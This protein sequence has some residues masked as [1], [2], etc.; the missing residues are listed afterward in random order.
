MKSLIS[1]G[2]L[3]IGIILLV[4]LSSFQSGAEQPASTTIQAITTQF[5]HQLEAFQ[6]ATANYHATGKAFAEGTATQEALQEAHLNTRLAFKRASYLLEYNDRYSIKK[7]INGAPL[8]SVEPK[9]PEVA[10]IEPTGLQVLD[11]IVFADEVAQEDLLLHLS[12]LEKA[13]KRVSN[14]Q[15]GLMLGHRKVL[16]AIQLE[17]IRIFTLG[18]T[19]FDTPGSL[20]A[21]PEAIVSLESMEFALQQYIPYL[22]GK[23]PSLVA[24]VKAAFDGALAQLR[25]EDDFDTFNRLQFYRNHLQ[26]LQHTVWEVQRQLGIETLSEVSSTPPPLLLE[27]KALF[28]EGFFND[29]YFRGFELGENGGEKIALG[30]LLF[31]DPVLSANNERACA[32]CHN[33][34]KAFTDG[35]TTSLAIDE[36]HHIQRNSPTLLNSM[37]AERFFYDL[38]EDKLERQIKHVVMDANEFSTDFL[39]IIEKL[40]QSEEYVE[41]FT[42]AYPAAKISKY[43]I[44]NA[45]AAY[46]GTLQS[47][48]SP[49]D[50]YIT[51][52]SDELDAA[53][54]RGFNLFMGKAACGTCHFA[55]TFSG[56]VPPFYQ[57]NESEVL[58][59]PVAPDS[60][61]VD[62]DM[63]RFGSFRPIDEAPFYQFSFKTTTVRNAALT[64]PYMHNGA[65][66]D[67][68]SVLDFYN[69]GGGAGLGIE[70]EYQT[71]P[72]DSLDLTEG[73]IAD[74]IAF[75]ESLTDVSKAGTPPSKLPAFAGQPEWNERPIGGRY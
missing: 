40:A 64:A 37:Y 52:R 69:K 16:E 23:A 17:L 25:T 61:Q 24:P 26:D 56:L 38:R 50:Q 75:M 18:L 1:A 55:P 32:S 43:S 9:V 6:E 19:G 22:E 33:P 74:L 46:V 39:E 73:E 59:V 2:S 11:E 67:L 51:G 15:S 48:N 36:V 63:G 4:H 54:E 35:N 31:Y 41:R 72:P 13:V 70:L 27:G 5:H 42:A 12:K 57:E 28:E 71:L 7:D 49:F 60:S 66:P 58:G 47:F 65:Y 45:L 68:K 62:S 21:I 14:Y 10:V 30:R 8:P 34:E 3:A 53:A 44:S 29:V 20:H